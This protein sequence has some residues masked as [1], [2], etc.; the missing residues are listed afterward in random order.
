MSLNDREDAGAQG[1]RNV[2]DLQSQWGMI[3]MSCAPGPLRVHFVLQ[4]GMR[5][6]DPHLTSKPVCQACGQYRVS[7]PCDAPA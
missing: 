5:M 2:D 6:H 4:S 7:Q 1:H 3:S